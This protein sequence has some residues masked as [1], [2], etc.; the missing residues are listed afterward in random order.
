[1]SSMEFQWAEANDGPLLIAACG[2]R[3][4]WERRLNPV[5]FCGP[6]TATTDP[7][8]HAVQAAAVRDRGFHTLAMM[9]AAP[10]KIR[11]DRER[12]KP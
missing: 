5:V 1:M 12:R 8:C 10:S 2:Q 7:C 4:V 11:R 3:N 9:S 6:G